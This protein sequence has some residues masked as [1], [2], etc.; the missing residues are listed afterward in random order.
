MRRCTAT[1]ADACWFADV[2]LWFAGGSIVVVWIVFHS[3]NLDYRLIVAGAVLPVFEAVSGHDLALHTL[4]APVAAM[5][6]VMLAT[7]RRRTIRR[8]WLC[9]PIGMFVH[10]VLDGVWIRRQAFWWPAFGVDFPD[11]RSL[12]LVRPLWANLLLELAGLAALVW[13][14]KR[15]GLD[16]PERRRLMLRTGTLDR[17]L[18]RGPEAG[19]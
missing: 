19:M 6:V 11:A 7:R 18:V 14:V 2:F 4:A 12:V 9:L 5:L 1:S 8:R 15:F 17:S 3:A 10:L 13:A 16:D